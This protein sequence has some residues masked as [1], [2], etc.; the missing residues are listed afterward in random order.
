M[1]LKI[2]TD[3][4]SR[5]NPGHAAIGIVIQDNNSRLLKEISDY[6][7]VNTNNYA[8]YQAVLRA[9]KEAKNLKADSVTLFSDSELVCRQLTG[10]YRVKSSNIRP[11]FSEV[12]SIASQFQNF[13]VE[14]IRRE[15]N[16]HADKLANAALD[17]RK[18]E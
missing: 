3:G 5:G 6:I 14:H 9:L 13:S 17:N 4:A 8:E 12:I 10:E 2:F 18:K 11:L 16:S 15:L 7:G 1:H